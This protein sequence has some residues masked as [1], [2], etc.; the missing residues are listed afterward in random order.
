MVPKK[1]GNQGKRSS[2]LKKAYLVGWDEDSKCKREYEVDFDALN[3][4]SKTA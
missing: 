4:L 1:G 2:R 3:R